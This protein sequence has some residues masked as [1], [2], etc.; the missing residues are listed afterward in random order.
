M[1]ADLKPDRAAFLSSSS[2]A[3]IC[4]HLR[5]QDHISR[6]S[7]DVFCDLRIAQPM[8]LALRQRAQDAP[9]DFHAL[10]E[11]ARVRLAH[12]LLLEAPPALEIAAVGL[13]QTLLAD[14]PR[15][16]AHLAPPR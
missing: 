1:N 14:D 16:E 9:G 5:F 6:S 7:L 3:F 12:Q 4:V 15:A 11:R 13:D 2:S 8:E 10:I